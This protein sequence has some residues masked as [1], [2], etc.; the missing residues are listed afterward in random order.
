MTEAE[1]I[2]VLKTK[3]HDLDDKIEA[4]NHKPY[5]DDSIVADL[6]RRKL[7][8]KDELASMKAL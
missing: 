4:E 2:E 6:K 7:K 3:H 5:P 1:N 8:I